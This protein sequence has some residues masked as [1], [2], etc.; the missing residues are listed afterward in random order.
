MVTMRPVASIPSIL[1]IDE[2]DDVKTAAVLAPRA[3]TFAVI[4]TVAPTA[5]VC[6]GGVT[7][8]PCTTP[9]TVSEATARLVPSNSEV[10]T[11]SVLPALA[12]TTVRLLPFAAIVPTLGF[13]SDQ[14]TPLDAVPVTTTAAANCADCPTWMVDAVGETESCCTVGVGAAGPSPPPP[15]PEAAPASASST[16]HPRAR[17]RTVQT[18]MLRTLVR[19]HRRRSADA[20]DHV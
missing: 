6:A 8:I 11:T 15:Q 18:A 1:A 5:T 9:T 10:A 13:D 17:R 14:V 4:C 2:F 20:P 16:H 12:P 19:K 7:V 3:V